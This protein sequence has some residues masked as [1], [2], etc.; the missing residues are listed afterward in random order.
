MVLDGA[1]WHRSEAIEIPKNISLVFLPPY[2][3]QLNPVE[4]LWKEVRKE[5]F[6][7]CVFKNMK[8]VEDQLEKVLRAFELNPLKIQ[9]FSGFDW[10]VSI[11]LT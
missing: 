3:P 6:Y 10:I 7:N 4:V 11:P 9:S 5:G 1:S 2:S 8:S